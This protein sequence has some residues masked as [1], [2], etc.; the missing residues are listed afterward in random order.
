L[1]AEQP[2]R[3]LVYDPEFNADLLY[4]ITTQPRMAA[5]IMELIEA[6]RPDPFRGI[7]KPEPL[8]GMAPNTWSR[9]I[10]EEHRLVYVVRHD[11]ITFTKA[12]YHYER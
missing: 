6:V 4:W 7:G 2:A 12:R 11:R 9:R 10:N 5:R 1:P 3:D 8:R